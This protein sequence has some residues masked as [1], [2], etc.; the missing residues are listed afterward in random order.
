MTEAGTSTALEPELVA[1][2]DG[3]ARAIV[4]ND[5]ARIGEYM[6]EDWV[7][8]SENGVATREEFLALVR[9]GELTHSAMDRVGDARVRGY[10]D[11]AV[12]TI[13]Q[14]NTA[15]FRGRRFDADEWV[16]DVFVRRA[17]GW[18]CVLSQITSA[19]RNDVITE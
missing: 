19:L 17:G 6:S 14:T 10:G 9:S 12:L 8:V 18:A 15:H 3:W 13:R 4:S 2:A 16:S 1:V 7:I 11:T 5:A